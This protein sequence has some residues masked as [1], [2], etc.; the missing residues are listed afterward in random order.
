MYMRIIRLKSILIWFV[1][2]GM[3]FSVYS[4]SST[5]NNHQTKMN[6]TEVKDSMD[7][8]VAAFKQER[9]QK[10][11][12]LNDQIDEEERKVNDATGKDKK[13]LKRKINRIKKDRDQLKQKIDEAGEK[14][15]AQW[16]SFKSSI[17][18][19]YLKLKANINDL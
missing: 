4:C 14:T 19:R 9:S 17:E 7:Q 12:N 15:E 11:D 2:L 3:F 16:N 1:P 18:T 13:K 6:T 8:K 10:M 5:K